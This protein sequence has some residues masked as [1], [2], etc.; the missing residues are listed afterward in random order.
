MCATTYLFGLV[1]VSARLLLD[2]EEII[3]VRPGLAR[4]GH[5]G[6]GE[7]IAFRTLKNWTMLSRSECRR[8]R[9]AL[10][11]LPGLPQEVLGRS[12][13]MS[14]PSEEGAATARYYCSG[15]ADYSESKTLMCRCVF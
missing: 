9:S 3:A 7:K 11:C 15:C 6:T 1:R 5:L 4:R 10:W 14:S 12:R 13:S 2:Q 8:S